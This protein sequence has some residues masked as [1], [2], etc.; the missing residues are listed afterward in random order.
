M[1]PMNQNVLE[2]RN[3]R[4]RFG[5]KVA[6]GDIHVQFRKGE[7]VVIAGSNGAGKSTLLRCLA[8]VIH[9]DK[10]QILYAKDVPREKI[11]FISDGLSL[12]ENMTL[13]QGLDFHLRTFHIQDPDE[14]FFQQL[15]FS[16]NQRIKSLSVGERTLY[17]LSLLLSQKPAVLLI[18]EIIHAVDPYL[19]EKFLEAVIEAIDK[20]GTTMITINHTFSEIQNIPERVLMME[21][22]RF[23]LDEKS[24]SLKAKIKKVVTDVEL[25]AEIPFVFK[26]ESALGKEYFIYPFQDDFRRKYAYDFRSL[27]LGEIIKALIGGEYAKKRMS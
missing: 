22:G 7:S 6:L 27:E 15:K 9:P 13:K 11:A 12:F 26:K 17:H 20:Y 24:E 8:G 14:S 19:R 5:K 25:P 23:I 10:G 2:V 4:V 18:D 1:R 3:L 21:G 16:L